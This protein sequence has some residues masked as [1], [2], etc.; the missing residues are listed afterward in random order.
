MS[1]DV[2]N[3]YGLLPA[4]Y[5]TRDAAVAESQ[6]L[7]SGPLKAL[8]SVIA[9]QVAGLEE[10]IE[11]LYDDQFIE[12]CADWVVPYI[13]DLIEHRSLDPTLQARAGS[14]RAEVANAV[15]FRRRKGTAAVIEELAL[16]VTG[17][18]AAV[19]E[20]FQ[21][22]VTSQ[23]LNHV[24]PDHHG[25]V[26]VRRA[27][28]SQST[29]S[30]FERVAHSADAR[31]IATRGGRY[32]IP[33][34]GV[35]LWRVGS[36]RSTNAPAFRVDDRRAL[37]SPLGDD[38]QL[39]Q[40]S[41]RRADVTHLSGQLDVPLPIGRRALRANLRELYGP[42]RSLSIT[43]G[44]VPVDAGDV[45]SCDLRDVG[46]G[47]WAHDGQAKVAIDP[48]L[49]RI[50]LPTASDE[51]LRVTYHHGAAAAIGG[52]EYDRNPTA[53]GA[54]EADDPA[55][56]ADVPGE[57]PTLTA[58]LAGLA[59][60]GS[61]RIGDNDVRAETPVLEA[62]AGK[63]L[64][65]RAAR[66]MRPVLTLGGDLVVGGGDS[67]E[68]VLE[69]LLIA[70]GRIVVPSQIDGRPNL[71]ARLRIAHCT[72][73]PDA[74]TLVVEAPNVAVEIER[75]IVG[76]VE[77]VEESQAAFSDSVIDALAT[78]QV[79]YGGPASSSGGPITIEGCTVV[80]TVHAAEM[81]ASD[82]ILQGTSIVVDRRQTGYVRYSHVPA[83][84]QVPRRYACHADPA[85]FASLRFGDPRY[86][87]LHP[88]SPQQLRCG[89]SDGGEMG[90]FHHVGAPQRI[91]AL[92]VR[93]EE[94]L[95]F[96]LE[97]GL[98]VAT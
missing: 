46:S 44:G 49:G 17:W 48:V 77:V 22:L 52:G 30:A 3:V 24:R 25:C 69:G 96:G 79:A 15:R 21:R 26:E 89:A 93:L 37:F 63:R 19:V 70:G 74:V 31:R 76:G 36:R 6:G 85:V 18:D 11:Q 75:S 33:N 42:G 35:F 5:R 98:I 83:D 68:V 32:N 84:G 16:N 34:V 60:I 13:G 38:L 23:H 67:A 97:A 2:E 87:L 41:P 72:L 56:V 65:I 58:A 62:A 51:V 94:Y 59:G 78:D 7:E 1:F 47:A 92:N 28:R 91:A 82:A 39:Y 57:F 45:E 53:E 4:V 27:D 61:V 54:D 8:L 10:N 81:E 71:L 66:G 29:G 90:V 73:V 88:A 12:T 20:F 95:R 9:E 14:D 86:C 64:V 50:M 55:G 43:L 40:V 80:G